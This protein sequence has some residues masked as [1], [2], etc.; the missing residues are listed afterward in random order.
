MPKQTQESCNKPWLVYVTSMHVTHTLLEATGCHKTRPL[1]PTEKIPKLCVFFSRGLSWRSLAAGAAL[2]NTRQGSSQISGT[3][4]FRACKVSAHSSTRLP[5]TL[6]R[7]ARWRQLRGLE[8]S[9]AS[10]TARCG[11]TVGIQRAR[12]ERHVKR[13]A[14]MRSV[15]GASC[16]QTK[17]RH[18]HIASCNVGSPCG[19]SDTTPLPFP[20]RCP[21]RHRRVEASKLQL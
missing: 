17:N 19:H 13:V 7:Q 20:T 21:Q 11:T 2:S 15:T 3:A 16:A 14:W 6:L 10:L 9:K 4:E 18:V 8:R 5:Q 1:H 12:V